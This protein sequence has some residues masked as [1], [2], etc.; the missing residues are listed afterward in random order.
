M[1]LK[2]KVADNVVLTRSRGT[3]VRAFFCGGWRGS[4]WAFGLYKEGQQ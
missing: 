2:I 1:L 3:A 4:V